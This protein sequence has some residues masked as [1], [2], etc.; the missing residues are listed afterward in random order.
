MN[1][2][3]K[4]PRPGKAPRGKQGSR[5][6]KESKPVVKVEERKVPL[7]EEEINELI[8]GEG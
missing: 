5:K 6:K 8:K 2:V 4:A 7:T 1:V 3:S